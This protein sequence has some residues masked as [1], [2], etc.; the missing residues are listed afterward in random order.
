MN[1]EQQPPKPTRMLLKAGS[2]ITMFYTN[3]VLT[4]DTWAEG[5]AEDAI[6]NGLVDG[7]YV[8]EP[9]FDELAPAKDCRQQGRGGC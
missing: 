1:T 9:K 4:Q 6:R 8:L 2:P 7:G 3:F 5:I